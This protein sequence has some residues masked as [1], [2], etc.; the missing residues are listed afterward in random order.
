MNSRTTSIYSILWRDDSS[1]L[2]ANYDST[3]R[4]H[5]MRT[6][7]DEMTWMDPFDSSLF[8]LAYDG[9]FGVVCGMSHHCRVNLYDL[10]QPREY[11]QMYHPLM[12]ESK[13]SG[14][15]PVYSIACDTTQL[16][17][18]TDHNLRVLD[19]TAN[20]AAARDYRNFYGDNKSLNVNL[21]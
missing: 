13:H 11:V 18:A 5:D 14:G 8:S 20:W 7:A 6:N 2:T 19:F 4:L 10:R 15:S 21:A 16:F 12:T 3:L 9:L 17:I 1:I